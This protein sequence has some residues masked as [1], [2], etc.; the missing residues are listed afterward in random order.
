MDKLK[1]SIWKQVQTSVNRSGA[2]FVGVAFDH[3]SYSALIEAVRCGVFGPLSRKAYFIEWY[4]GTELKSER[5]FN[6]IGSR[7]EPTLPLAVAMN[8]HQTWLD[9][10]Q[11]TSGQRS[12]APSRWK[13]IP[14]QFVNLNKAM[15]EYNSARL[16]AYPNLLAPET[17]A[18]S[19]YGKE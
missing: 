7:L 11:R 18:R 5:L 17:A 2:E 10:A 14:Y 6:R 16:R 3:K 12:F 9:R 4:D 8:W 13:L 19:A 15:A 1:L